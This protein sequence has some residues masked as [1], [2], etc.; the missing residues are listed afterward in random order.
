MDSLSPDEM[1]GNFY[2][3]K[4]YMRYSDSKDTYH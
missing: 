4:I 2:D 3:Q 1:P